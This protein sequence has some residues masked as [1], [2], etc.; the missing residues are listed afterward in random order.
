VTQDGDIQGAG[1]LETYEE[2]ARSLKS[3]RASKSFSVIVVVGFSLQKSVF[4]PFRGNL[5]LGSSSQ[6][7]RIRSKCNSFGLRTRSGV[8]SLIEGDELSGQVNFPSAISGGRH[9]NIMYTIGTESGQPSTFEDPSRTGS[10]ILPNTP[11][12]SDL[13]KSEM[14]VNTILRSA[15]FQE[16]WEGFFP[17]RTNYSA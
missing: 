2:V 13:E 9:G 16:E 8:N 10:K 7:L 5:V 17:A 11:L 4:Q 12:D 6:S 1:R 14:G 3:F 15:N